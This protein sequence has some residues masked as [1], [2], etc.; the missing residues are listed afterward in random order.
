MRSLKG[1]IIHTW[2]RHVNGVVDCNMRQGTC[3]PLSGREKIGM[4]DVGQGRNCRRGKDSSRGN[5]M[6]QIFFRMLLINNYYT[7]LVR[8]KHVYTGTFLLGTR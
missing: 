5:F 4:S 1:R 2:G 8:G 6:I 7:V 3:R